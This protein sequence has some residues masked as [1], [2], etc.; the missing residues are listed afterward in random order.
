MDEQTTNTAGKERREQPGCFMCMN[1]RPF[2]RGIWSDET[3]GHFRNSRIEFLK[4][5]RNM[6]DDRISKLSHHETR[7]TNVTVE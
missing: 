2:L 5:V 3:R 1:V 6:I 4:G 7:G